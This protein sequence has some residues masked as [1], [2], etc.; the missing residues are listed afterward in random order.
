MGENMPARRSLADQKK[1]LTRDAIMSAAKSL[2]YEKGYIFCTIEGIANLAGVS[3][4]SIYNHFLNKDDLFLSFLIPASNKLRESGEELKKDIQEGK[5][6]TG[7]EVIMAFRRRYLNFYIED[8]MVLRIL[9]L[10]YVNNIMDMLG[11]EAGQK[12]TNINIENIIYEKE[13][14]I[15]AIEFK[16]LPPWNP[17]SLINLIWAAFLG[18][19][20]WE[21]SKTTLSMNESLV[22]MGEF[23][24]K[25]IADGIMAEN[26]P[27]FSNE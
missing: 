9:H 25:I 8:P 23:A 3:R 21:G 14:I 6:T 18:V 16:L 22:D 7:K 10:A 17:V 19:S 1:E 24:F 4:G 27:R 26:A 12:Y 2:F 5:I 13:I 15:L 11:K 20:L